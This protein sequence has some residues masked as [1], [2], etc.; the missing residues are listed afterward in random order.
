MEPLPFEETLVGRLVA[1]AGAFVFIEG[2]V[3]GTR[4]AA[5]ALTVLLIE[6][7]VQGAGRSGADVANAPAGVGVTVLV[8]AAVLSLIPALTNT[9]TGFYVQFLIGATHI[10]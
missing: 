2:L 7:V 6:D 5:C 4:L 3:P 10:C 9:M 8:W 1:F